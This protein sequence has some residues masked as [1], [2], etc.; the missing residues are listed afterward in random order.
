MTSGRVGFVSYLDA[1]DVMMLL[2]TLFIAGQLGPRLTSIGPLRLL[3]M[4]GMMYAAWLL[5]FAI[6]KRLSPYPRVVE[7]WFNW[8]FNGDDFFVIDVDPQP[9]PLVITQDLRAGHAMRAV[10]KQVERHNK[11]RSKHSGRRGRVQQ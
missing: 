6:K 2:G 7:Y 1:S 5:N 10:E 8:W 11:H 3:L 9:V 4:V